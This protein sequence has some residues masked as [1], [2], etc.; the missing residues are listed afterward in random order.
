MIPHK[1]RKDAIA[2]FAFKEQHKD[3]RYGGIENIA[4]QIFAESHVD[5]CLIIGINID[6]MHYPYSL[7]SVYFKPNQPDE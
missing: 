6:K 7:I 2:I 3:N 5:R 4:S 1:H